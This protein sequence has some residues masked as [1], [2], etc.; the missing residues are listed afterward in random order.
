VWALVDSRIQ[1][2]SMKTEGWE[3]ALLDTE[4]LDAIRLK[5]RETF[6]YSVC[7][8]DAELDLELVD[9]DTETGTIG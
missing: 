9:I 4:V 1:K 6:G 3:E 7:K 8:D 5:M 2:W